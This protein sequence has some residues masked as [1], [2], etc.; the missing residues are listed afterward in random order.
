MLGDQKMPVTYQLN[1]ETGFIETCCRGNVTLEE[2][3]EHFKQLEADPSLPGR[4]DVLLDLGETTSLPESDELREV[5]RAV[6]RVKD[7]VQWGTC[8][9]IASRDALF[10]MIRMFEV[11]TEGL[12]ARTHVFRSRGEAE[13]Y[14]ARNRLP[15]TE[16]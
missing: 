3:L 8:A 11:F 4:L 16:Q 1:H 15:A 7:K 5:A 12:F 6:E 10:G 2:V 13:N 9:I 14:L